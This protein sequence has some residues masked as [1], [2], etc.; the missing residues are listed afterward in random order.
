MAESVIKRELSKVMN[1]GFGG[2]EYAIQSIHKSDEIFSETQVSFMRFSKTN[3]SIYLYDN[4]KNYIGE[5][6]N[7]IFA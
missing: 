5:I 2:T 6:N 3:R 7:V 1:D 4:N